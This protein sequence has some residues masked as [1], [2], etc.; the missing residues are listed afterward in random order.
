MTFLPNLSRTPAEGGPKKMSMEAHALR[1][2]VMG[3]DGRAKG[4][5]TV[6]LHVSHS[7]LKQTFFQ[8]WCNHPQVFP[9]FAELV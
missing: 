7:N 8:V 2:Y 5:T 1:D 3:S 4:E 9:R 6:L